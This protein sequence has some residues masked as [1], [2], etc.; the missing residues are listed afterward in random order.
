VPRRRALDFGCGAGRLTQALAARFE[1]VDG[2]DIAP[3]MVAAARRHNRHPERCHYHRNATP[4]LALFENEAFT[5]ICSLLVLQHM[6]PRHSKAYLRELLR[7]LAP[8]GLLVFQLPSRRSPEE[9]PLGAQQTAASGPLPREA[10]R[11]RIATTPA[12]LRAGTAEHLLLE[13]EVENCSGH[14]WPCLAGASEQHGVHLGN[15]WLL[16]DGSVCQ[17]DDGRCPL[18]FDL[19]PGARA[20]LLLPV[21]APA[22]AGDY[23]L[24]LDMV[25]EDV[26]WFQAPGACSVR[27]RC[28]VEGEPKGARPTPLPSPAPSVWGRLLS[29]RI[30]DSHPR[31]YQAL[32][33]TGLLA[34]YW[35]LRRA[36]DELSR[37][38][39][40]GRLRRARRSRESRMAMYCMPRR[41]VVALLEAEGAHVLHVDQEL[42][43]GGFQ[44]CRYWVRRIISS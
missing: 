27:V 21:L 43:P 36:L 25:Q 17:L 28:Q 13:V 16:G 29:L 40:E 19:A 33:A 35:R 5:F 3:S 39:D 11:A 20:R 2:V 14:T 44:S 15:H 32:H 41:E 7:L 10:R 24:E 18:P 42:D 8:D 9:P 30:R 12:S 34:L 38:R 1:R 6:E 4:D 31:L 37:R 23:V 22:W 26:A